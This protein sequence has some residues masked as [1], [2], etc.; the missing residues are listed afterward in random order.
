MRL[1]CIIRNNDL[2]M[3]L[4]VHT[5]ITDTVLTATPLADKVAAGVTEHALH[6]T[7]P[8][9][10]HPDAVL[11]RV[12]C[13]CQGSDHKGSFNTHQHLTSS[14]GAGELQSHEPVSRADRQDQTDSSAE[15]TI[16]PQTAA[17]LFFPCPLSGWVKLPDN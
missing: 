7:S 12:Q 10:Q 5:H 4:T 17:D 9:V 8:A 15:H 1:Q 13:P 2:I 3:F 6:F 14:V 11:Q 16:P